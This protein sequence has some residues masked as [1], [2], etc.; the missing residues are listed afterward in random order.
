MLKLRL[1]EVNLDYYKDKLPREWYDTILS[2]DPTS[3]KKYSSWLLNTFLRDEGDEKLLN[4]YDG[5]ASSLS[6]YLALFDKYK[7]KNII[8]A[9]YNDINSFK[10]VD[11]FLN[12]MLSKVDDFEEL[13][14]MKVK[15]K[16]KDIKVIYKDDDHLVLI[17]LTYEA[18]VKYGTGAS[19]CT[20]TASNDYH[21]KS[22]MNDG[23]LYIHRF[24]NN[25]SFE[26]EAYQL[27]IPSTPGANNH[28]R[29]ECNDQTNQEVPDLEDTFFDGLPEDIVEE[30]K[31]K[32]EEA[33][34]YNQSFMINNYEQYEINKDMVKAEITYFLMKNDG[35]EWIDAEDGYDIDARC[36]FT[37]QPIG[38]GIPV[39]DILVEEITYNSEFNIKGGRGILVR[40]MSNKNLEEAYFKA[41]DEWQNGR[42]QI[43]EKRVCEYNDI[44]DAVKE[45]LQP[46][47]SETGYDYL[48]IN[49]NDIE[50]DMDDILDGEFTEVYGEGD[51]YKRQVEGL[52]E[53]YTI[54]FNKD[55]DTEPDNNWTTNPMQRRRDKQKDLDL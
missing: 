30:F 41:V 49:R 36:V 42:R 34:G 14:Q 12:Y 19:W 3:Q 5:W 18:S 55:Y 27:Y 15:S 32:I 52:G 35:D 47:S 39:R 20:A 9:P 21:C 24:L 1:L 33:G 17:P 31:T 10:R 28:P 40:Y 37:L 44:K 2:Y 50:S 51:N 54:F 53:K 48:V 46:Y 38:K 4:V 23:T 13:L 7:S 45:V 26:K 25:G 6:K 22:Y 11:G 16:G 8:P 29:V 43:D